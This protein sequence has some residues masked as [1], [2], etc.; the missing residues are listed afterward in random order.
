MKII[1]CSDLHLD[2]PL[3]RH[4][5]PAQAKARNAELCAAFSR[6][7]QFARR[8]QVE[9]VLIVGDL[10][11]SAYA[12]AQTAGFVLEQIRAAGEITFFYIRGNH[13]G[14]RDPLAGMARQPENLWPGLD[15]LFLRRCS[16]HRNGAGPG[17]AGAL[18]CRS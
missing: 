4:F 11:D 7:V 10:F 15:V 17:K 13:D 1:H 16:D 14:S 3:G 2:S 5:T 18:F 8:E 12:S 6:M 9:A